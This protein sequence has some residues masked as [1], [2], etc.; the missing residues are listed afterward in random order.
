MKARIIEDSKY[1]FKR[2]E[3]IPTQEEVEKFYAQEFYDANAQYFNNSA[4]LIQQEQSDF[5]NSRWEAIY[6][7]LVS[8]FGDS[9]KHKSVFDIGFGFAQALIYLKKKGL[10]VSGL[11]PSV[12]GVAYARSNGIEA[13]HAGV[14]SFDLVQK[15]SDV[16][17]LISVLEHLREPEKTILEIKDKMLAP[18]GMLVIDVPNDFN[19]FQTV[20][21]AEYGLD[22]WWVHPPNHINYF[23]HDSLKS[24]LEGCG[25]KIIRCTSSFP[26]DMFLLF[27]DQYIG[28]PE[29]GRSCHNKRVSFEMLMEKHG[30]AEKLRKFN[31]ALAELNLGRMVSIYATP[32]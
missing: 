16:V 25:F 11:E 14:E 26:L 31:D 7:E 2:V 10:S 21:N 5:F 17:M 8:F 9:L 24:L 15:K 12:E 29:L 22:E 19:D 30:K 23:S 13:I 27:G 4:L 28:N 18:D 3:P 1:G 20:A 6:Q 32:A